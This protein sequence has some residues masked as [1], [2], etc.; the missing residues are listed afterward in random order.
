MLPWFAIA[1]AAYCGPRALCCAVLRPLALCNAAAC[2]W[3][4][5]HPGRACNTVHIQCPEAKRGAAKVCL[6]HRATNCAAVHLVH[7]DARPPRSVCWMSGLH[8]AALT[9]PP[10]SWATHRDDRWSSS[11]MG[12]VVTVVGQCKGSHG[13]QRAHWYGVSS[14]ASPIAIAVAIAMCPRG[15]GVRVSQW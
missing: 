15:A 12:A 5:M 3:C 13:Q 7:F 4:G 11:G 9:Q 14:W 1:V 2:A 10:V 8:W 6:H